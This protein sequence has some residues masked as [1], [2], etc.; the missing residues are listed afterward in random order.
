MD[1]LPKHCQPENEDHVFIFDNATSHGSRADDALSARPPP[2][3]RH[4]VVVDSEPVA[5]LMGMPFLVPADGHTI[6]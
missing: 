1:I 5:I 2:R 6:T 3:L 4:G